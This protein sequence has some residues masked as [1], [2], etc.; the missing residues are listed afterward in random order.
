M[1]PLAVLSR[2]RHQIGGE[3]TPS[4]P[5]LEPFIAVARASTRLHRPLDHADATFDPIPEALT[6]FEPGLFLPASP[7][8][9]LVAR[10][11]QHDVADMQPTGQGFVLG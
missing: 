4:N 7:P 5:L 10:F 8:F 9:I 2:H 1:M 11:R 3:H 6:L